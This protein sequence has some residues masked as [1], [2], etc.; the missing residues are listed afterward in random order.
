MPKLRARHHGTRYDQE[1]ETRM[2]GACLTDGCPGNLRTGRDGDHTVVACG[3]CPVVWPA[4]RWVE[5]AQLIQERD[6]EIS[7]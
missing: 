6:E 2:I 7:E 3:L 4:T 1:P 5:L